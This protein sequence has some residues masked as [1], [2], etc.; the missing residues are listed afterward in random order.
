MFKINTEKMSQLDDL[1]AGDAGAMMTDPHYKIKK[2]NDNSKTKQENQDFVSKK[3]NPHSFVNKETD[4][5]ALNMRQIS[6]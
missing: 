1:L 5:G 2:P 4:V 6:F 3:A